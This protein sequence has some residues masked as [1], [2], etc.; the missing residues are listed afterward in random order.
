MRQKLM[1]RIITQR[2]APVHKTYTE[3][4]SH[5][6]KSTSHSGLELQMS[7]VGGQEVTQRFHSWAW[8]F[9]RAASQM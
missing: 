7:H 5:F 3:K 9:L 1:G 6:V 8:A 4:V 2:K